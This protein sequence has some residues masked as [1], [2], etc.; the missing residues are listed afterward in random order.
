M[1]ENRVDIYY[2]K[3]DS[4]LTA[5]F[6]F[7]DKSQSLLGTYE[8]GERLL[9]PNEIFYFE[10]VEKKCF[11]YLEKTVYQVQGNLKSLEEAYASL[12]F[13]RVNKSMVLNLFRVKQLKA[14]MNMKIL[15]QLENGEEIMINRSYKKHFAKQLEKLRREGELCENHK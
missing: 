4:E 15:A 11:A 9:I 10:S 1:K 8:G 13:V 7:L 5:L 2:G 3:E 6:Q 14:C 12:G